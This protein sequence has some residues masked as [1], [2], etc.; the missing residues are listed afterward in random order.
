MIVLLN[1]FSCF[2][3]LFATVMFFVGSLGGSY[4]PTLVRKASWFYLESSNHTVHA[5]IW[6]V[7]EVKGASGDNTVALFYADDACVADYCEPCALYGLVLFSP[8][9][10]GT[11]AA[12]V[13]F[14]ITFI[15]SHYPSLTLSWRGT[16]ASCLSLI[17][18][19]IGWG[20]FMNNC[21][22]VFKD[23]FTE[24]IEYGPGAVTTLVG[25]LAMFLVVVMQIRSLLLVRAQVAD[26]LAK[27][28]VEPD[29]D[30]EENNSRN[31]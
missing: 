11:V 21:Y 27:V 8:L 7:I 15:N 12:F 22:L 1:S 4:E 23:S 14:G 25:C 28:F 6:K 20:A 31:W 16:G 17:T 19:L 18:V 5:N 26:D 13:V 30:P 10:F 3:S 9:V 24:D 2:L 29:P